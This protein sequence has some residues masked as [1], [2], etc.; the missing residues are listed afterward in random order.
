[1]KALLAGLVALLLALPAA[2]ERL[3]EWPTARPGITQRVLLGE[4]NGQPR[5]ALVLLPGNDGRLGLTSRGGITLLAG[6]HL[7]RIRA[8]LATAGFVVAVPDMAPDLPPGYPPRVGEANA[9]DLG[10]VVAQLR[11]L[12][13]GVKVTLLGTSG[14]ALAVANAAARLSGAQAPD[15]LVSTSGL[16]MADSGFGISVQAN[17]PGLA[18]IRAPV[19]LVGHAFDNC[20]FSPPADM[21]RFRPLL[22]ASAKVEVITLRGG[23]GLG[24]RC[25]ALSAHG[26]RGM[27]AE[28]V[29]TLTA[30]LGAL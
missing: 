18:G 6:D 26:F 13:P 2:A 30:W 10:Q 28:V 20:P 3:V 22:V 25:Q 21:E 15:G 29:A 11:A 17:V 4:P 7:V 23:Y 12:A 5:G 19:L 8:E 1:M 14:G 24:N 16:L 9:A 27:D